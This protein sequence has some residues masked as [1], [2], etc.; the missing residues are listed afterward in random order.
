MSD[1]PPEVTA[2][3]PKC[4]LRVMVSTFAQTLVGPRS[5]CKH[6]EGWVRCPNLEPELSEALEFLR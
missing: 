2:K 5:T 4:G 1:R 6:K 3:C